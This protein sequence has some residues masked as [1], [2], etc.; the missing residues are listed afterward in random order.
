MKKK[1]E[2]DSYSKLY[3]WI[4]SMLNNSKRTHKERQGLNKLRDFVKHKEDMGWKWEDIAEWAV[5]AT[6]TTT[7]FDPNEEG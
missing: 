1:T 2:I 7:G 4:D 6:S 5:Y 3:Y